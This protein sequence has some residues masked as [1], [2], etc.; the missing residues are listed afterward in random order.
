MRRSQLFIKTRREAPADEEAR[1]AQLLIRAGYIHKEMAGV[2]SYFTL[3]KAVLEN[4]STIIREEMNAI[5]GNEVLMSTLQNK[6]IWE[7]TNRWDDKQVDNWFKSR[8]VSGAEVGIGFT[9]EEPLTNGLKHFVSSYKDLPVYAYQIQTKFRNELRA[10]N[11][12]LRGRE[13]LMKDLYSY[14][15]N[16]QEH[17]EF[18]EKVAAAYLKIFKRLGFAEDIT[19]RTFAS[20]GV[21]TE[22]SDE[23]QIL[24]HV[25]EDTIF[26]DKAKKLA[27][28][29]EVYAD[30]I[31]VKLGLNKADLVEEKAVEVGNIF[32]LGS[33][34][35]D[36]L[37]LVY[38][39]DQ[40][41]QKSI[42]MGCY[43]IGVSRLMGLIAEHFADDKGLVWPVNIAPFKVYLASLGNDPK[44]IEG[45][46]SAYTSLTRS[47]VGVIYDDRALAT[48]G[49]KLVD[50]D[51]MGI[52]G[53]I[54]I[55]DKTVEQGVVELKLRTS[56]EAQLIP[57]ND[58]AGTLEKL[59]QD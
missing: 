6:E 16:E 31:L 52:P 19:Y 28:N 13:F 36:A 44:V 39:D 32:S 37:G 12:L 34:Y 56:D 20:G 17:K 5:G 18:Y 51:L 43:G 14:S 33:K 10:K 55:S 50:A 47:G 8:L 57:N 53:R 38:V 26:L 30:E 48:A 2:Y 29:K 41:R 40:G 45:A 49:E 23:F 25:G 11:G 46:E 15:R 27:I 4:V 58:L 22:F 7:I 42:L 35:S 54:V 1:N 9:H 21:F 59:L 3:G 24:S